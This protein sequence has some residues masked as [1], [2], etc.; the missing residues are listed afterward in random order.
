[1]ENLF[2]YLLLGFQHSETAFH[3]IVT[4]LPD[5]LSKL[6]KNAES[7]MI[8]RSKTILERLIEASYYMLATFPDFPDLYGP[9]QKKLQE[10]PHN[11]PDEKRKEGE[12]F[13]DF[14]DKYVQKLFFMSS[15][16]FLL[17]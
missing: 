14:F 13:I 10:F 4:I 7:P 8:P 9:L 6:Q 1:M 5:I 15:I 3:R 16:L 12:D 2:F 11:P 17:F